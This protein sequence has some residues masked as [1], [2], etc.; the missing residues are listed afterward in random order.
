MK[1]GV[2]VALADSA[3]SSVAVNSIQPLSPI[4]ASDTAI[5]AWSSFLMYMRRL[6]AYPTFWY[7]EVRFNRKYSSRSTRVSS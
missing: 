5:V 1:R 6:S 3:L 7:F 4:F 2:T